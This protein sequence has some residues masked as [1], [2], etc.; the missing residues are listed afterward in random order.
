MKTKVIAYTGHP[1][2]ISGQYVPSGGKKE[3]TFTKGET[4]PPNREG[5]RQQ[6]KLVDK[7]KHKR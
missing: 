2:P 5:V 1:A 6:F 3:F 4:T 7:T